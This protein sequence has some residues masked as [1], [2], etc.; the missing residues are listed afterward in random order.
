MTPSTAAATATTDAD[1]QGTAGARARRA[2]PDAP[3]RTERCRWCG[4][5]FVVA[6]GRGRPRRYCKQGCRQQAH[7]ARK[8]AA[9]HGLGD[10]DLVVSRQVIEE[11][12]SRLYCLQA[13]IEDVDR[14]LAQAAAHHPRGEVDPAELTEALG[15]LLENAR[16]VAELWVE[17]RMADPS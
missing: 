14:D 9:S 8:L 15:W 5:S 2:A 11:L 3:P 7:L 1:P 10:D 16:P 17:P 6:T 13:A 4:R 12:Q